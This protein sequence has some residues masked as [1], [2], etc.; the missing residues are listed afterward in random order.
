[1]RS[2]ISAAAAAAAAAL[3]YHWLSSRKRTQEKRT[4]ALEALEAQEAA[5]ARL[6]A[7]SLALV[8]DAANA[9]C[10]AATIAAS[11]LVD[12]D[13]TVI[14]LDAPSLERRAPTADTIA[15]C[16]AL[17]GGAARLPLLIDANGAT[18]GALSVAAQLTAYHSAILRHEWTGE[19]PDA[20]V[21]VKRWMHWAQSVDVAVLQR[22]Y[23]TC[24]GPRR[25]LERGGAAAAVA[26]LSPL[27]RAERALALARCRDAHEPL[28][29][30]LA[31]KLASALATVEE[32][33][34][35]GGLSHGFPSLADVF[36]FPIVE[37]AHACGAAPLSGSVVSPPRPATLAWRSALME[38]EAFREA[39]G[40]IGRLWGVDSFK[41]T[42][43]YGLCKPRVADEPVNRRTNGAT[44]MVSSGEGAVRR[45]TSRLSISRRVPSLLTR[46]SFNAML[47]GLLQTLTDSVW[48]L[49]IG[50]IQSAWRVNL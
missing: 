39:V 30:A 33:L 46:S 49:M 21:A 44:T 47:G 4:A 7:T 38:R 8:V 31:A 41:K 43:I 10:F 32:A 1:M 17:A 50:F 24:V 20:A 29:A 28:D 42:L 25:L 3:T 16:G 34:E 23:A 48:P 37:C 13:V 11:E 26:A 40:E 6:S 2:H 18:A 9:T 5:L 27:P 22:L 12:D 14:T 45:K 35:A 36:V 19:D 15:A